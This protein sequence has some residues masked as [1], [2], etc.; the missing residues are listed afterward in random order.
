MPSLPLSALA[1]YDA[2]GYSMGSGWMDVRTPQPDIAL[3]VLNG[4]EEAEDRE[5]IDRLVE[6]YW[7][8][9]TLPIIT[10]ADLEGGDPGVGRLKRAMAAVAARG[11]SAFDRLR[12]AVERDV[13]DGGEWAV[14][15][16]YIRK[17]Y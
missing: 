1:E 17:C 13:A 9:A 4:A 8:D 2:G 11:T 5:E 12:E 14:G 15:A 6:Q 3:A 10:P 16:S 7:V